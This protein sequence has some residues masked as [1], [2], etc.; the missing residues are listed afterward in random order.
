MEEEK[1]KKKVI[2][3]LAAAAVAIWVTRKAFA[4]KPS[5]ARPLPALNPNHP[6]QRNYIP[7]N[8]KVIL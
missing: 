7:M 1:M 8:T 2:S 6:N 3:V 5:A 4:A